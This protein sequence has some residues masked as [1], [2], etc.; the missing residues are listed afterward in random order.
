MHNVTHFIVLIPV[1]YNSER[2]TLIF[3]FNQW[4]DY[5]CGTLL[6]KLIFF[7]SKK[8]PDS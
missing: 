1:G 8:F 4:Q 2:Y 7:N 5:S 3:S 6:F